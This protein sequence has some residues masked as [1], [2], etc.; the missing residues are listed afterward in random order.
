[1][2]SIN[3]S[4]KQAVVTGAARGLGK[5][6][7][8][9]YAQAGA[10][11][12]IAD[13]LKDELEKTAE[14][15]R[16][17]GVKGGYSICDVSEYYQFEALLYDAGQVDILAHV[18]GIMV[19][20]PMLK[21][22]QDEIDRLIKVNIN[23]TDNACRAGLRKMIPEKKGT[24]LITSSVAGRHG[25]PGHAHY[26]LTKAADISIMQSAALTGAPYGITVNAICP[27][28]IRTA[29]WE[30]II[31][32]TRK[33]GETRE[34]CWERSIREMV[35]LGRPQTPEDI[36]DAALFLTSPMARNITGQALNVCGAQ[37]MN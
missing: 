21:I 12:W 31:D 37:E 2:V 17:M 11:V 32:N 25:H 18:A 10:D 4:G 15:I 26:H 24:I 19:S 3:L 36:A 35:P 23:G 14:E 22:N 1:M 16:S 33:E 34:E 9:K 29:I 27:G 30:H 7:A 5:A 8:L 6:V 28:I 20:K 13:I